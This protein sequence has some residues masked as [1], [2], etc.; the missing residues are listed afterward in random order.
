MDRDP[1]HDAALYNV[2]IIKTYVEYLEKYYPD[3][4]IDDVLHDIGM[5][6]GDLDDPGVWYTQHVADRFQEIIR[7]K[8]R[9]PRIARDAGRY[10]ASSR[11]YKVIREYIHGVIGPGT[12]YGILP[13]IHSKVSRSSKLSVRNIGRCTREVTTVPLPGV[14]EK[15]YQCENRT[16]QF[17]AMARIFTGQYARVEHPECI[18][19]NGACC[20]YIVSWR[21]PLFLRIRKY[22]NLAILMG[23]LVSPAAYVFSETTAFVHA[24]EWFGLVV[25]SITCLGLFLESKEFRRRIEEQAHSAEQ[26][27]AESNA[28]Y[29][30][31]TLIQE[32]GRAISNSIDIDGLLEMVV[33]IM[34]NRLDFDRGCIFLA[35]DPGTRLIYRAGYG[36]HPDQENILRNAHLHLDKPESRGPLVVCFKEKKPFLVDNTAGILED[37]SPRSKEILHLSGSSSFICVPVVFEDRALGVLAVDRINSGS[38]LRQHDLNLLLGIAPQIA[39]CINNARTFERLQESE[40]KYRDLVESANSIIL[41]VDRM[42]RITFANRYACMFY[43]YEE[44]EML[45][46]QALGFILPEIDSL[47]RDMS[48]VIERFFA[49]PAEY[50]AVENENVVRDGSKVWVSWSTRVVRD[51]DG[52]VRE[53]LCVGNDITARRAAEEEKRRL[54]DQLIHAQKMEAIGNLAGGVAHDLNNILSGV[55]GYPELLLMELPHDSPL[56]KIAETVKRSGEK[57]A[58]MVQDL[59]TLARRGVRVSSVVDLN[60]VVEDYFSSPEFER[61]RQFHPLV[62]FDVILEDGLAALVGSEVHIGKTLMNL[63]SNAAEAM[64]EG[65][66][67]VVRT[68]SRRLDEP[69]SGYETIDAGEYVVLTVEDTGTGISAEDQKKIFEPFFTK[70]VMGR[71]GTGLGMTVVWSTVKDHRGYIDIESEAGKGTRIDIYFP[72]TNRSIEDAGTAGSIADCAGTERILVVDDEE[73]QLTLCRSILEKLGY[74]V[75]T[76]SSGEEAL[77]YLERHDADLV[78]VDMMLGPGLDGLETFRKI[79]EMKGTQKAIIMSGFSETNR[80]REA[81]ELGAG[82]FLGKP[83]SLERLARAVR[84]ELDRDR[85]SPSG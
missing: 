27:I 69:F 13:S 49:E 79:L 14:V 45:G 16:G 75:S 76:A 67:V 31:A 6:R 25:L 43:G 61:L 32:M 33:H 8:T 84:A 83:F 37:L 77:E 47:G 34:E 63:V 71:S 44:H 65:G 1:Q 59:L 46:R 40:E 3:V 70:K 21:E 4:N 30:D 62:H 9:N 57:A 2:R 22:R 26:L 42:G 7:S 66:T 50:K 17:E 36:F 64:P 23:I 5:T 38:P 10:V 24:I 58:S 74:L 48:A 82:R 28:R 52:A 29:N 78:I 72:V 81:L 35:D 51:R 80:V 73:D 20:R 39:I 56:R 53:I 54:E 11:A 18:H 41:R 55:I 68:F 19:R 15:P 85:G 60:R 12:A